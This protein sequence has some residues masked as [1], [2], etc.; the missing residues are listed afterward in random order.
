[1]NKYQE[2][3]CEYLF[4][5]ASMNC[6][7]VELR[8]CFL[9]KLFISVHYCVELN[10]SD[11][12]LCM[13]QSVCHC[14]P[15]DPG[16]HAMSSP[17]CPRHGNTFIPWTRRWKVFMKTRPWMGVW[18]Y[19]IMQADKRGNIAIDIEE[20]NAKKY[21]RYGAF[22]SCF[23]AA[24]ENKCRNVTS[25]T[26]WE[27]KCH[28]DDMALVTALRQWPSAHCRHLTPVAGK[29]HRPRSLSGPGRTHSE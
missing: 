19:R 16:T 21:S 17:T 6:F 10:L 25:W 29:E 3:R 28:Q 13:A 2:R 1:M 27:G 5:E 23:A 22:I 12:L 14:G 11:Q 24:A 15:F 26:W 9:V 7:L 18:F 20:P 4:P 8:I